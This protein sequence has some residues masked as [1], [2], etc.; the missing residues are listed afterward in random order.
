MTCRWNFAKFESELYKYV[1]NAQ[2]KLL[3]DIREKKVLDDDIKGRVKSVLT[4]FKT[5]FMAEH[6]A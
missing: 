5:R 6:K 2:P 4:E 3:T 1:E